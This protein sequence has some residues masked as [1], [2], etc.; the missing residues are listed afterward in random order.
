[1]L[2]FVSVDRGRTWPYSSII[3]VGMERRG[4]WT[5]RRI[6]LFGRLS[7]VV[8]VSKRDE[9]NVPRL[10]YCHGVSGCISFLVYRLRA[11]WIRRGPD[12]EATSRSWRRLVDPFWCLLIVQTI[13][14]GL[15]TGILWFTSLVPRPC[16]VAVTGTRPDDHHRL[17]LLI[18]Q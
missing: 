16:V 2:P 13:V 12:F 17:R 6:C 3:S 15:W 1:M 11:K 10:I 8:V 9:S 4:L 18:I 5:L 7:T 14:C